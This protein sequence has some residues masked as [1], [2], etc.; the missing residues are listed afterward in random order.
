MGWRAAADLTLVVH[1]A[2]IGFTVFG[3]FWARRRRPATI[4]H[5]F[6]VAYGILIEA[7]G[8]RCPLTPLENSF[9]HRAG[10]SGYEEGFVE[11]YL[12]SIIYPGGLTPWVRTVLIAGLLL[13]NGIAY[14]PLIRR[15]RE[16]RSFRREINGNGTNGRQGS[17]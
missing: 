6:I 8:F 12:V 1:L 10:E 3:G 11:H 5:L 13:I 14:L 15:W 7:A 4:T 9:R 17:P 2:F 16:S